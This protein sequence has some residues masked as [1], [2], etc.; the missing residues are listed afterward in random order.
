M[1]SG[2]KID[3]T[4]FNILRECFIVQSRLHTLKLVV[5]SIRL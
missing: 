1:F 4:M 5:L 3:E 2:W